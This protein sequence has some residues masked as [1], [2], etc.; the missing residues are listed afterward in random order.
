MRVVPFEA[1]H[2]KLMK[3]EEDQEI[4][5]NFLDWDKHAGVIQKLSIAYTIID[6]GKI[7]V[8]AGVFKLWDGTGE[9]WIYSGSES[10]ERHRLKHVLRIMRSYLGIFMKQL[11]LTRI[12]GGVRS[13]RPMFIK[14]A[15]NFG[16]EV[17]GE[18]KKYGKNDENVLMMAKT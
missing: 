12:Q 16:F 5:L 4:F 14:F 13:D 8:S 2:T 6:N 9:I 18:M 7:I 15:E 10:Y 1:W 17:E 3:T 11:K